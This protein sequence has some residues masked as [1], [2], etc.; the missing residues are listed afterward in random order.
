MSITGLT[1]FLW[2][3]DEALEAA[4]FYVATFPDSRLGDVSH[5]Q[6]GGQKPEG[7]VLVAEFELFGQ[8]FAALNGGPQFTHSEAVS[9]Q[10]H[11]DTQDEIDLL[12]DRLTADG[13]QE[14]MC[15]WCKDRFGVSWQVIP[16]RL[17]ELLSGGG[18][19]EPGAAWRA[20]MDMRKIV[21]A[22]LESAGQ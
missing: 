8:R 7:A 19:A 21:I 6:A 20:M 14:S 18:D 4:E 10:V 15:G 22:D 2:F 11:C 13:G 3:D 12:W 5:Y 17:G 9:F 1:T 16:R